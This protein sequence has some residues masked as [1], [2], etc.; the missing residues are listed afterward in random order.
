MDDL[1]EDELR[2]K[3][4]EPPFWDNWEMYM[5]DE[6]KELIKSI[7]NRCEIFL[8]ICDQPNTE[9]LFPTLCEDLH[10]DSQTIIDNYCIVDDSKPR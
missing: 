6:Q 2:E 10:F 1:T 9:H 5:E 3:Y 4:G 7:R 8:L